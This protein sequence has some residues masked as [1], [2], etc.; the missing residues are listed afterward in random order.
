ME[1]DAFNVDV[2]AEARRYF[3]RTVTALHPSTKVRKVLGLLKDIARDS[4]RQRPNK[5]IIFSQ[6]SE[7]LTEVALIMKTRGTQ[8]V[9]LDGEML[10]EERQKSTDDIK[11]S[12]ACNICYNWGRR[13]WDKP[14]VE[15]IA[16]G[17]WVHEGGMLE[18]RLDH[19]VLN[20]PLYH[21]AQLQKKKRDLAH[22]VLAD[23]EEN[24]TLDVK[25]IIVLL[26]HGRRVDQA[27]VPGVEVR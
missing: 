27:A 10:L 15:L 13:R 25:D 16:S 7:F 11:R 6:W 3:E 20:M 9:H 19:C 26:T 14:L 12:K 17:K 18:E 2:A 8:F 24:D 5:T 21:H 4:S 1:G 22:A 23:L